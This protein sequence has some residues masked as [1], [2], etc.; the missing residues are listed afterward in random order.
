MAEE[1]TA[2]EVAEGDTFYAVSTYVAESDETMHLVEGERVYILGTC[3]RVG[4]L[5]RRH[6]DSMVSRC[7]VI[8]RGVWFSMHLSQKKIERDIV[9][10]VYFAAISF[11]LSFFFCRLKERE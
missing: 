11:L 5:G 10:N 4:Q 8:L 9:R 3:Q 1:T 2:L 7:D 6:R